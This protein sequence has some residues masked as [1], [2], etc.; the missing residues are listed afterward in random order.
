MEELKNY[1]FE[2]MK[3]KGTHEVCPYCGAAGEI[4]QPY[5]FLPLGS[6][7]GGRYYVGKA[8]Q[9]NSEGF[10]YIAYDTKEKR[11][12]S[13]R[14]FFPETLCRRDPETLD[15]VSLPGSL[16]A[17][18]DCRTSF[19]DLWRKLSRLKGLTSLITVYDIF[20]AGNTSYAVYEETQTQTL[21][22]RLLAT[23]EGYMDWEQA[24]IFFMPVLSTL[25]TLHTSGVIHKG[26][27]P[28]AFIFTSDGKLKLTD[29]SIAQARLSF[30]DLLPDIHD[31][32]APLEV[33]S[34]EGSV[35]PWTDIYS[36]SAVLYRTLVG[37]TPIPA[38]VRAQND[39][40]MIPAK[41]A[42]VLPPYVINALINGMQI[43]PQDRTRNVEQ[44]RSNLSASPRAVSATAGVYGSQANIFIP[45]IGEVRSAPG[46]VMP[47]RP[48]GAQERAR[49][50]DAR[51]A[52]EPQAP[53]GEY[54]P[55]VYNRLSD[56]AQDLLD[57]Q[58]ENQKRRKILT[59]VLILLVVCL[60]GG[61]ALLVNGMLGSKDLGTTTS[62]VAQEMVA[63][64][65]LIHTKLSDFLSRP[66]NT[67]SFDIKTVEKYDMNNEAGV[68]I[69]QSLA[70]NTEVKK[71]T[72]LTLQV[73]KG[74]RE[75][76]VP[77]VKGKTVEQARAILEADGYNLTVTISPR[78]NDGTNV[79]NTIW[80]TVPGAGST[81][82]QGDPITLS[83]FN[84]PETESAP[85]SETGEPVS[86]A[87]VP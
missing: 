78:Y 20:T 85:T 27:N 26:L 55:P 84:E 43:E 69:G 25:G 42:E 32:Y 54:R 57:E 7:V 64:P 39:Q 3:D 71:G 87:E 82:R 13:L 11:P 76:E 14:E 5:P 24:R 53:E 61:V 62:S 34:E 30:G 59:A 16:A 86:L 23:P 46:A 21:R 83:V 73:S 41:F 9:K 29:F 17:Y 8:T 18:T 19:N 68:I 67:V 66:N 81:I 2:C 45:N 63:V 52:S 28:E 65:N 44:L 6:L 1:C 33:Y 37:V 77:D 60:F 15:V 47:G 49:S 38:P 51:R 31:G 72:T 22:D 56:P 50:A 10:T 36:F 58:Q 40:M 79:P 4:R 70:P 75:F 35:G 74:K 48:T 12:C 80:E